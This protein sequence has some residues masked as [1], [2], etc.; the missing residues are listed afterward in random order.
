MDLLLRSGHPLTIF[1]CMYTLS[2]SNT[3]ETEGLSLP[4][5][6]RSHEGTTH[7]FLSDP[8]PAAY[9]TGLSQRREAKPSSY[10]SLT[11]GDTTRPL[12]T[13]SYGTMGGR[14]LLL[15]HCPRGGLSAH[16]AP[17]IESALL[18]P[19]GTAYRPM[20]PGGYIPPPPLQWIVSPDDTGRSPPIPQRV[21][22]GKYVQRSLYPFFPFPAP[23]DVTA[24][25]P[26]RASTPR[27]TA[28][29]PPRS[30]RPRSPPPPA[31]TPT[32]HVRIMGR[33][34]VPSPNSFDGKRH[35]KTFA[36]GDT[37]SLTPQPQQQRLW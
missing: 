26:S 14:L 9:H 18:R 15:I 28:A 17:E 22:T 7:C 24:G 36:A 19:G 11:R 5:S 10:H 33:M 2:S 30:R 32:E 34:T 8:S 27:R 23:T 20:G 6:P 16:G 35:Q 31:H 4:R 21:F 13:Y 1:L 3:A 37:Q 29:S 25:G 12:H